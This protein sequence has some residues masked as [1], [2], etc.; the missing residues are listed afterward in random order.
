M[1]KIV[2]VAIPVRSLVSVSQPN[3]MQQTAIKPGT[4]S[5]TVQ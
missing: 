5:P 3:P 1:L 2:S 4:N